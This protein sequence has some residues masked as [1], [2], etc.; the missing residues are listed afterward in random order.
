MDIPAN[1]QLIIDPYNM[2]G[3]GQIY[4]SDIEVINYGEEDLNVNITKAIVKYPNENALNGIIKTCQLQLKLKNGQETTIGDGVNKN[5]MSF[6]L[7]CQE[8]NAKV[9]L[10]LGGSVSDGSEMLWQDG[11]IKIQLIFTFEQIKY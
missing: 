4:S 2:A 10:T 9:V 1:A 8:E 6:A 11:D 7:G 3:K 5:V